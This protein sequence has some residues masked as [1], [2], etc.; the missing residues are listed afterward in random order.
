L[1]N[2][3]EEGRKSCCK[4]KKKEE[5]GAW[6]KGAAPPFLKELGQLRWL[7]RDLIQGSKMLLGQQV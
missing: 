4:P 2:F 7:E 6:K 5:G 3:R 1:Q